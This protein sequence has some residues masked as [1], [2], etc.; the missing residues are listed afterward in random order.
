MGFVEA[1]KTC[2]AKYFVFAGRARRSEYWWFLL[3]SMILIA[4]C[5]MLDKTFFVT[6][7]TEEAGPLRKFSTLVLV[8]PFLAVTHRRLHDVNR[9]AWWLLGGMLI[10]APFIVRILMTEA[11]FEILLPVGRLSVVLALIFY[12]VLFLWLVKDSD[13]ETNRFG[14]NAK[15]YDNDLF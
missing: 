8:L 15:A 4:F 1:V 7:Q 3:F 11:N 2:F 13:P 12:I 14:P 6:N 9:T 5:T 10:L